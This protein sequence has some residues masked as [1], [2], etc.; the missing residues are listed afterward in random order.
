MTQTQEPLA[1]LSKEEKERVKIMA[2][3]ME[4]W[5]VHA[6]TYRTAI[7]EYKFLIEERR[8]T[9]PRPKCINAIPGT[10]LKDYPDIQLFN[11][12]DEIS[13]YTYLKSFDLKTLK[14]VVNTIKNQVKSYSY[15]TVTQRLIDFRCWQR[16]PKRTYCQTAISDK[17]RSGAMAKSRK[18]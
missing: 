2:E 14:T 10:V 11:C 18:K 7:I 15:V 12:L 9:T 6:R 1:D 3:A 8:N 5:Y 13:A 4:L 16:N 17:W